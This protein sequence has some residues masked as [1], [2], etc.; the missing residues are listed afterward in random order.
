VKGIAYKEVDINIFQKIEKRM[1]SIE[2]LL[3]RGVLLLF[4]W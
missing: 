3:M 1:C 2:D 4:Q